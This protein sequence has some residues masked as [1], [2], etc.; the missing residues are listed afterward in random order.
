MARFDSA[1]ALA[2]KLIKKNGETGTIRRPTD[3]TA[4]DPAKPW[5]PGAS[6][7]SD[8]TASM[9]FL[10]QSMARE[11]GTVL[12]AGQQMVLIPASGLGTFVPDSSTD[13]LLRA[14]GEKW[15]IE[16]VETLNP[17][18]QLI[19]HTLVVRK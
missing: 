6:T 7:N 5:E 2:L 16:S 11:I 9:V 12:T 10:D 8:Q 13:I 15:T 1:I 18:G 19:L 17:N 3:G 4:A 14:S